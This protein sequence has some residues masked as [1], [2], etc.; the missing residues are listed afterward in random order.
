M[1]TAGAW[2]CWLAA[3][4]LA[5]LTAA[6]GG[7]DDPGD[8]VVPPAE[9]PPFEAA[10][11]DEVDDG[12]L[13]AYLRLQDALA[14]DRFGAAHAAAAALRLAADDGLAPLAEAAATAED[15]TGLRIAFRPLSEQLIGSRDLPPGFA[16]AYCPMA[17][18]YEGG[19][20]VQAEGHLMNPYY[21]AH[22]LRCGA[23]ETD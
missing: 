1:A 10:R 23:F 22:M 15:I 21:G 3:L 14:Y 19:R 6:C 2:R 18:D 12:V 4:C 9:P 20:W 16:V 13:R 5:L 8:D 7:P 17:F 11:F